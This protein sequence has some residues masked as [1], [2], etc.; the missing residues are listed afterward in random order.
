M[1]ITNYIL[2]DFTRDRKINIQSIQCDLNSRFVKAHLLQNGNPLNLTGNRVCVASVT[3]NGEKILNDCAILDAENGLVQ[4][5]ITENM[6]SVVGEVECQIKIFGEGTLLSSSIFHLVIGKTLSHT[7]GVSDNESSTLANVLMEIQQVKN[8]LQ[9]IGDVNSLTTVEK[10]IIGAIN[11][12]NHIATVN[13]SNVDYMVDTFD[14]HSHANSSILSDLS[15]K[16]KVLTKGEY[17]T[18]ANTNSIKN[19]TIY[20]ITEGE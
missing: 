10:Q 15:V 4:F 8:K 6:G 16:F 1:K 12:V 20:L 18:L 14:N 9:K 2:L 11:E 19:D 17:T 3:P 13:K 5:V 7:G